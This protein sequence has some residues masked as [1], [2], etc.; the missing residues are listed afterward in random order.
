MNTYNL[1]QEHYDIIYPRGELSLDAEPE[2]FFIAEHHNVEAVQKMNGLFMSAVATPGSVL[3]IEGYE[4]CKPILGAVFS[5]EMNVNSVREGVFTEGRVLGW[6]PFGQEICSGKN[7]A[8]LLFLSLLND[9]EL[10][11]NEVQEKIAEKKHDFEMGI[12]AELLTSP[13]VVAA[14]NEVA[15]LAEEIEGS[16]GKI[17]RERKEKLERVSQ[18]I[19]A[20]Q[21]NLETVRSRLRAIPSSAETFDEWMRCVLQE[22]EVGLE[23]EKKREGFAIYDILSNGELNMLRND[24]VCELCQ[25]A[26]ENLAANFPLRTEMMISTMQKVRTSLSEGEKI[27]LVAGERHLREDPTCQDERY[28]LDS[29]YRY[30]AEEKIRAV[31]LRPKIL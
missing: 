27:F 23:L 22:R 14:L 4:S 31:V 25:R 20:Q 5:F 3:L 6:D 30:L 13:N 26:K 16:I 28:R 10:D 2:V 1:I 7:V 29:F 24:I 18:K 21:A 19:A 9:S 11:M 15:I 8:I 17:A 12:S